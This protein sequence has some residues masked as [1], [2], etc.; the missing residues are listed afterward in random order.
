MRRFSRMR[1]QHHRDHG[2]L[3][4]APVAARR[5][6]EQVLRELLGDR[7]SAG[8]H[9]PLPLILFHRE[10]D[11]VPVEAFVVD[12]L[13]ILGGDQRAL[14]VDRDALVR[15][16]AIAKLDGG[17][18]RGQLRL[19]VRHERR[20][21]RRVIAPP[22]DHRADVRVPQQRAPRPA[23]RRSSPASAGRARTLLTRQLVALGERPGA[24]D[25]Q[26]VGVALD[27]GRERRERP[28]HLDDLDRGGVEDRAA[29]TGGSP[30]RSRASRRP[31]SKP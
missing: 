4:L 15:D 8:D 31:G 14:Q 18:L 3:R 22:P 25:V 17:R 28:G 29:P 9:A 27:V 7:R 5:R 13:R 11:A 12:E 20:F 23:P 30:R 10:L 16:V 26:D 2:L 21:G 19:A 6:Q 1:L 24:G